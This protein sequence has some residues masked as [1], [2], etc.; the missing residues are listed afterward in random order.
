MISKAK[1]KKIKAYMNVLNAMKREEEDRAKV[2]VYMDLV[3]VIVRE[4]ARGW[5]IDSPGAAPEPF[6]T[7]AELMD[8]ITGELEEIRKVYERNGEMDELRRVYEENRMEA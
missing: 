7:R 3:G 2:N 5:T 6:N 1:Q 4:D 8:Y